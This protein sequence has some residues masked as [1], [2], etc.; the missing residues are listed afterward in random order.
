MF[1]VGGSGCGLLQ[2]QLRAQARAVSHIVTSY[3]VF[4]FNETLPRGREASFRTLNQFLAFISRWP[5][6][7][8]RWDGQ[9]AW[10]ND[11]K[12]C[13]MS[14]HISMN[15]RESRTNQVGH[16][17]AVND[18]VTSPYKTKI[19]PELAEAVVV[20]SREGSGLT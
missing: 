20:G 3:L 9:N 2:D 17:A 18:Q 15:G 8:S 12:L 14:D 10:K 6:L 11:M 13:S 4:I 16:S 5:H 7:N 19:L 1:T